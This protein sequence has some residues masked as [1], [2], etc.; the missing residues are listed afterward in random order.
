MKSVPKQPATLRQLIVV[1][2]VATMAAAFFF[3]ILEWETSLALSSN[4][5]KK[6]PGQTEERP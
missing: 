3:L 1:G 5:G 6:E 4:P 2:L